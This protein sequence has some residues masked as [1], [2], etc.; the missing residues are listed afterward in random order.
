MP[1]S[2]LLLLLLL[3]VP[4]IWFTLAIDVVQ[5]AAAKLGFV[6]DVALLL[7]ILVILGST[8][9]LPLYKTESEVELVDDVMAFS[10]SNFWEFPCPR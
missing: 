4:L 7:L 3:L 8:I 2:L 1:V 10:S 6:P 5:I 9:N